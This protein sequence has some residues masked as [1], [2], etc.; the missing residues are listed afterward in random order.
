MGCLIWIEDSIFES[1][2]AIVYKDCFYKLVC[3]FLY[4]RFVQPV[5]TTLYGGAVQ[6]GCTAFLYGAFC[7]QN[8]YT[9][10]RPVF[11]KNCTELVV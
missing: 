8:R 2:D 3:D 5:C 11:P 10:Q 6:R 7:N 1:E 9:D 4:G